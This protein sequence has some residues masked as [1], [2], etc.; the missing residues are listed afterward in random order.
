MDRWID[1]RWTPVSVTSQAEDQASVIVHSGCGTT[2]D[3]CRCPRVA[4]CV[5][6]GCLYETLQYNPHTHWTD[7][8]LCPCES[9]L[10]SREDCY[11]EAAAAVNGTDLY[12]TD[13]IYRRRLEREVDLVYAERCEGNDHDHPFCHCADEDSEGVG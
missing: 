6:C 2:L 3:R 11:R 10:P 8:V 7:T 1:D 13:P 9:V 12:E 5:V 4:Q